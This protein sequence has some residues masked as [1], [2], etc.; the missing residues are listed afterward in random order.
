MTNK[1]APQ[2]ID[3]KHTQQCVSTPPTHNRLHPPPAQPLHPSP[4]PFHLPSPPRLFPTVPATPVPANPLTP[5]DGTRRDISHRDAEEP[6]LNDKND[7]TGNRPLPIDRAARS[8]ARW[9]GANSS[10]ET[11]RPVQ[12]KMSE[13]ASSTRIT[14]DCS[15]RVSRGTGISGHFVGLREGRGIMRM[16]GDMR[17]RASGTLA[18]RNRSRMASMSSVC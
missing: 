10:P 16:R 8:H 4:S 6:S 17:R 14:L 2:A 5:W 9:S 7:G 1:Q 3:G 12:R 18:L 15:A 13:W 11:S